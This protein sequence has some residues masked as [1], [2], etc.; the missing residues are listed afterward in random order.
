MCDSN[1]IVYAGNGGQVVVNLGGFDEFATDDLDEQTKRELLDNGFSL[2]AKLPDL[3]CRWCKGTGKVK[4]LISV[5][6][7]DCV[8]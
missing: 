8:R 7:C 3:K 6:E 5:T 4:L 2:T 1:G